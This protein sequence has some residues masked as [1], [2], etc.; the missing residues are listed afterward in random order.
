MI[1]ASTTA[2]TM[3]PTCSTMPTAVMT[4]SIENTMSSRMIC[5][6]TARNV[7]RTRA[8]VSAS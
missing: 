3:T 5:T 2:A 6:I 4:E 7:G 1:T 8:S